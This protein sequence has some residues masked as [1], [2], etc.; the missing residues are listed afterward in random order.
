[1]MKKRSLFVVNLEQTLALTSP[2]CIFAGV[3]MAA[4]ASDGSWAKFFDEA[5]LFWGTGAGFMWVLV[6]LMVARIHSKNGVGAGGS[7]VSSSGGGGGGYEPDDYGTNPATGS[8]LDMGGMD[9]GG[10]MNGH[11]D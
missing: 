3:A 5:L 8:S 2:Y 7:Y 6:S 9:A 1:M 11:S 10:H 4:I